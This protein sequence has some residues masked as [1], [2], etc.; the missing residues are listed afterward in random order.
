MHPSSE[1]RLAV[2]VLVADDCYFR[3]KA[4][5][6]VRTPNPYSLLP[7]IQC[8]I[9][10]A[11]NLPLWCVF[12][13]CIAFAFRLKLSDFSVP[14]IAYNIKFI[15]V[16]DVSAIFFM[17]LMKLRFIPF[18]SQDISLSIT[19]VRLFVSSSFTDTTYDTQ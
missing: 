9:A 16:K 11:P 8:P 17:N 18:T 1:C 13:N 2:I 12:K 19:H 5:H 3:L 4:L 15:I 10:P 14:D 6:F 7:L